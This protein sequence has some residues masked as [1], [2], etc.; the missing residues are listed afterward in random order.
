MQIKGFM[1]SHFFYRWFWLSLSFSLASTLLIA[2]DPL[3]TQYFSNP[4]TVNPAFSGVNEGVRINTQF[5]TNWVNWPSPYKTAQISFENYSPALNSG[6]GLRLLTD[7]AGNGVLRTNQ[8][9]AVYAYQLR[10]NKEWFIRFGLE[11]GANQ[12]QLN[13]SKLY[14]EDQIDPFKGLNPSLPVTSTPPSALSRLELD[15]G[16]GILIFRDKG[17]L[18]LSLKHLNRFNQTFFNTSILETGRPMTFSLHSGFDF[19]VSGR[20]IGKGPVYLSP[21]LLYLSSNQSKIIQLGS[22]YHLGQL[23]TGVWARFGGIQPIESIVGFGFK[24]GIYKILYTAEIP[25]DGKGLQRTLGSHEIT[26]SL[27]FS[28]AQNYIS[29]KSAQ[30]TLNCFRFNN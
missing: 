23:I 24:K 26:L 2:Q 22:S 8:I 14:F 16:T 27:R 21:M 11:A 6:F 19:P 29:K 4:L 12:V 5:R 25:I 30:K 13:W 18:G 7:D 3:F 9:A 28:E 20:G 17:Y 10:V 15:L 1:R